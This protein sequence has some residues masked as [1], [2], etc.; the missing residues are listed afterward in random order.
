MMLTCLAEFLIY[1]LET[2]II[3][4]GLIL[5]KSVERLILTLL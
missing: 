4:V 3:I 5:L 2:K 1:F